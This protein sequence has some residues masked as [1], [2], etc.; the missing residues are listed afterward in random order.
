ME[1]VR[2][3][4]EWMQIH[5]RTAAN[6][7]LVEDEEGEYLERARRKRRKRRILFYIITII[8]VSLVTIAAQSLIQ[9]KDA[10]SVDRTL[11][12][13]GG[14][15]LNAQQLRELVVSE[16]LI[17]Y[18]VGDEVGA[19]YALN[20]LKD[21]EI[22]VRYLPDGNGLDDARANYRVV[23]TYFKENAFAS[24]QAAGRQLNAVGFTNEDGDAAFYNKSR[25][26]NVYI[27]LQA[28]DFQIEIYDPV[29][30]QALVFATGPSLVRRIV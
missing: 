14:V 28:T 21:N 6:V 13:R 5:K 22:Y 23:G 4:G 19:R 8:L 16:G 17:A 10:T 24:V 9:S 29:A 2:L 7:F 12:L 3:G 26:T 18:W 25:I 11:A 15:A 20:V 1:R 27:G 30:N